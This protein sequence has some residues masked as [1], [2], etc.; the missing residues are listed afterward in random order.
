MSM[1]WAVTLGDS[2]TLIHF[3]VTLPQGAQI[4]LNDAATLTRGH[5]TVQLAPGRWLGVCSAPAART[6]NSAVARE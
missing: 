3:R 5:R 2:V 4:G 1:S 6:H